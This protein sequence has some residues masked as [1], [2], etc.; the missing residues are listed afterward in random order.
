MLV[1]VAKIAKLMKI[2]IK[3]L[4]RK[5]KNNEEETRKEDEMIRLK[6]LIWKEIP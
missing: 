3:N 2:P 5:T 1:M 6:M 4:K